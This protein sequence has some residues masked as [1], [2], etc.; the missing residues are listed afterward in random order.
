MA[1]TFTVSFDTTNTEF[2][3]KENV[4]GCI[5]L[6]EK[7]ENDTVLVQFA[8]SVLSIE[9]G[10]FLIFQNTLNWDQRFKTDANGIVDIFDH[11]IQAAWEKD[12]NGQDTAWL[13]ITIIDD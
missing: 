12:E 2:G 9:N 7:R 1:K 4:L 8:I 11:R 3:W 6:E 10:L 13:E 5:G